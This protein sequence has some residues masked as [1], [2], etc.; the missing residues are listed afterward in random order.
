M[1]QDDNSAIEER[2]VPDAAERCEGAWLQP[3]NDPLR[4]GP[5]LLSE[6]RFGI[7]SRTIDMV[8]YVHAKAVLRFGSRDCGVIGWKHA[9]ARTQVKTVSPAL[10]SASVVGMQASDASTACSGSLPVWLTM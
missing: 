9:T 6:R 10:T 1:A 5:S 8:L 2:L 4:T 3:A 7:K